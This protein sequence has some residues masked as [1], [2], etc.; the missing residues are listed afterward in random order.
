LLLLNL[1]G[2]S[3]V[4]TTSYCISKANAKGNNNQEESI[5]SIIT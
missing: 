1:P 3:V 2:V 4:A 5:F